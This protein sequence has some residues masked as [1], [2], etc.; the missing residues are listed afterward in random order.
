MNIKKS[1][2]VDQLRDYSSL[3]S[4]SEVSR[5]CKNDMTSLDLKITRYD[6]SIISNNW[7]YSIYL[8]HIY[9]IIEKFYPNEYFKTLMKNCQ[10]TTVTPVPLATISN[11]PLQYLHETFFQQS[12]AK[13][14]SFDFDLDPNILEVGICGVKFSS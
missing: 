2:N 9:K 5:W 7:T 13:K 10:S 12:S 14:G 11:S 4:R 1:Y 8:K 6:T 3:F